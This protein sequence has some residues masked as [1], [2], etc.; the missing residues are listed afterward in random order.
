MELVFSTIILASFLA[1]FIPNV[2]KIL[3]M[4]F[5]AHYHGLLAYFN[6]FSKASKEENWH[7]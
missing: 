6:E 4:L 5:T 1:M 3:M 2:A 7:G